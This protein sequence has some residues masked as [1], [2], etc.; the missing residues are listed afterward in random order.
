MYI[1]T[2]ESLFPPWKKIENLNKCVA[3]VFAAKESQ[4]KIEM[5]KSRKMLQNSE[6]HLNVQTLHNPKN[7]TQVLKRAIYAAKVLKS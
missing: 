4:K 5:L 2:F 7:V 6:Y 3:R 1:G